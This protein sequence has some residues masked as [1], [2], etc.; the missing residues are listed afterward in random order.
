MNFRPPAYSTLSRSNDRAGLEM[1]D[2]DGVTCV[3]SFFGIRHLN[4][5]LWIIRVSWFIVYFVEN[6]S[7]RNLSTSRP[8]IR[9]WGI[10]FAPFWSAAIACVIG[11][12]AE[13]MNTISNQRSILDR[14]TMVCSPDGLLVTWMRHCVGY[15]A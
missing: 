1:T 3:I 12:T 4:G 10:Q 6:S 9:T 11:I 8:E 7:Q 15:A 14:N 5:P 13:V 2:F